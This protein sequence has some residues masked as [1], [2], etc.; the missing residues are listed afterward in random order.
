MRRFP[1]QTAGNHQVQHEPQVVVEANG[2][3]FAQP[4][5]L[6]HGPAL[7][8]LHS[9]VKGSHQERTVEPYPLECLPQDPRAQGLEI[10]RDVGQLGHRV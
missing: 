1:M 5:Q 3:P 2:D 7:E 6:A 8:G 9:R 4:A 10:N